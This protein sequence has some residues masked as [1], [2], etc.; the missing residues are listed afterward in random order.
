MILSLRPQ[1]KLLYIFSSDKR[2]ILDI[3][4]YSYLL[5]STL[6]SDFYIFYGMT[7]VYLLALFSL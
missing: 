1:E 7:A 2:E 5:V 4:N 6:L 3:R